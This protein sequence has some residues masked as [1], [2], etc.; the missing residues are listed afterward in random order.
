MS[1]ID[2]IFALE[3]QMSPAIGGM[4]TAF[5]TTE[6]R[7]SCEKNFYSAQS[8][9]W[10][11]TQRILKAVVGNLRTGF[12]VSLSWDDRKDTGDDTINH[13]RTKPAFS[14]SVRKR[15]GLIVHRD[16]DKD[17]GSTCPDRRYPNCQRNL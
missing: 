15:R 13:I 11:T 2:G 4:H 17:S 9:S 1:S 12:I 7:R 14:F 5:R 6:P 3:R 16:V 10:R 8:C